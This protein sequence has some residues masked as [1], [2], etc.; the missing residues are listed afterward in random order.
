MAPG[1]GQGKG[2]S[3]RF[4]QFND[5]VITRESFAFLRV[6]ALTAKNA[7]RTPLRT[8][9]RPM[10]SPSPRAR[11]FYV[12]PWG[13]QNASALTRYSISLVSVNPR[14]QKP[15]AVAAGG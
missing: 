9:A 8:A 4:L 3:A 14:E 11:P 12:S 13:D 15:P 5:S 1:R 10:Q 2:C 6:A 7:R